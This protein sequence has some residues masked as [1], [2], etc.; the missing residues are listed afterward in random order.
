MKILLAVLAVFIVGCASKIP[1][2]KIDYLV[3]YKGK[4]YSS[5]NAYNLNI[6]SEMN[7]R[8][9]LDGGYFLLISGNRESVTSILKDSSSATRLTMSQEPEKHTGGNLFLIC[10]EGGSVKRIT[11]IPKDIPSCAI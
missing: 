3:V 11:P 7:E 1:K 5:S 6:K 8:I 9:N 2:Q 4:E 10:E